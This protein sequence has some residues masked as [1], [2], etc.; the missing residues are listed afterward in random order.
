MKETQRSKKRTKVKMMSSKIT[1]LYT[2]RGGETN[3]K[4]GRTTQTEQREEAQME[5]HEPE[6][7]KHRRNKYSGKTKLTVNSKLDQ[8][9][10]AERRKAEAAAM[11]KK[12][13]RK[14]VVELSHEIAHV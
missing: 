6:T 9:R 12:R 4:R 11:H 5:L 1:Q 3:T 14:E 2:K 8:K 7:R 13:K 10:E